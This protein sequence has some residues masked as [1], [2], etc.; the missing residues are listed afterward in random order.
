MVVLSISIV[1]LAACPGAASAA[2]TI[3]EANL[4][5]A[6]SV[7]SPPGGVFAA[8]VTAV[9]DPWQGTRFR[10][11]NNQTCVDRGGG[12]DNAVLFNVT[13]P[14]LP[15]KYDA[16]FTA[17]GTDTCGGEQSAEK[18]L[19]D[20]LTVTAPAPNPDLP[21]RC[22][23]NVMLVLDRSGSIGPNAEN[24]RRASRAFLNALSGT[25]SQV[26][27]VDF[28]TEADWPVSYK[29]VTG[30]VAADGT[31]GTG[32]IGSHFEPYLAD[33]YR[34]GGW[35]NWEDAFHQVKVAN[36]AKRVADLVVFITDGDPTA[37]NTGNGPKTG[38]V[39][40]EAQALRQAAVEADRVKGQGS[41]VF[42][43]GVGAA[44]T[45][46]TSARRLTAISGFDRYPATPFKNADYTL[47]RE[48]DQ[49]AQALREIVAELCGAGISVTKYVDQ[50]DGNYVADNGWDFTATV[51]VQGG[52]SWIR[53][54]DATGESATATTDDGGIAR[55]LWRPTNVEAT[56][57]VEVVDERTDP[58]YTYVSSNCDV[59]SVRRNRRRTI[60]RT[61]LPILQDREIRPGE[62]VTCRVYNKINPGTIEI[63]KAATP[64]S[65][66]P[67]EFMGS[68]GTFQLVDDRA[69]ESVSRT[70]TDL[71]P[72]TYTVSEIV[73]D[74]WELTG[75]TCTPDGSATT[76]GTGVAIT[77]VTQGAVTCTFNDRRIDPPVPPT[78]PD[79]PPPD[80][81]GP[82]PPPTPPEPPPTPPPSTQLRVVKT[83]PSVA[84][85]GQRIGFRLTVTNVGSVAARRVRMVD[86]PPGSV[87]LASV[88][89]SARARVVNGGAV[90]RL[91]RLAPG[92]KRTIRG[93]VLITA[94]TPGWKRNVVAATAVNAQLASDRADT[95]LRA[96]Q[97]GRAPAVTG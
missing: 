58:G 39:E 34:P 43:L 84:R 57:T 56:S 86:L 82:P 6:T 38:L 45:T 19:T 63:E 17:T 89:S 55:F 14:A 26:S 47:V 71:A 21:Q 23:I 42:A 75:V 73:P 78:P 16:G 10:F 33:D 37:R 49:L 20:A 60:R 53:P 46:P 97:S 52:F 62:F 64:D 32:T 5:G 95:R 8:R 66:Q 2:V 72:G 65:R 93:S 69:N 70:F 88:R 91:G 35:T 50:G 27:I 41:R 29:P 11:G 18:V 22:G 12:A 7:S 79:P 15:N 87:A 48:F 25:G 81:P 61:S 3:T 96:A 59:K 51:S 9:G 24:V 83:M 77:L 54:A 13:A 40:G 67:F 68:L 36:D 74:N 80:P 85:V 30:Q 28:S 92:A 76:I 4:N 1:A 90:W 44:V 31:G 94:G